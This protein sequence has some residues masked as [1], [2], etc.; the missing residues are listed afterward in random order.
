MS[1]GGLRPQHARARAVQFARAWDFAPPGVLSAQKCHVAK[2]LIVF[3]GHITIFSVLRG[4][5]R[6]SRAARPLKDE[7]ASQQNHPFPR[8]NRLQKYGPPQVRIR[9]RK[10]PNP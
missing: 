5:R 8:S 2:F 4:A 10:L 3:H 7:G 6:A 9:A 1:T